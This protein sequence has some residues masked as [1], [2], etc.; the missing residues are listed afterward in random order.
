M[1]HVAVV[2]VVENDSL[3]QRSRPFTHTVRGASSTL[4]PPLII[5]SIP[6]TTFATRATS[7]VPHER[8]R[9][10][11]ARDAQH[12]LANAA[13]ARHPID[14]RRARRVRVRSREALFFDSIPSAS[15]SHRARD[16]QCWP[17]RRCHTVTQARCRDTRHSIH[18]RDVTAVDRKTRVEK[19]R[20]RLCDEKNDDGDRN[21]FAMATRLRARDVRTR[22][23]TSRLDDRSCAKR[24]NERLVNS[25]IVVAIVR[26][27]EGRA[28]ERRRCKRWAR[29]RA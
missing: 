22:P 6:F 20:I 18:S 25:L 26:A 12:Q 8:P 2:A 27:P 14:A 13:K 9:A 3:A 10:P 5:I 16:A 19:T 23:V 15:A 11:R 4:E 1:T 21:R 28:S 29:A 17:C 24:T 7:H